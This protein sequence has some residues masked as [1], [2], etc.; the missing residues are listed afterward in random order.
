MDKKLVAIDLDGTTLNNQSQLTQRTE[1]AIRKVI[2]QG[3]I[4]SIATGRPFRTSQQFYQQLNLDT[5]IVNFNGAWC[6]HPR[7]YNWAN[8]YHKRLDRDV[9]LS[10][11]PLKRYNIV[12]LISAE[13]KS[14]VYVDRTDEETYTMG[15]PLQNTHTIPFNEDTLNES[16]TS[17][18]VFTAD[19]H[20]IPF[21][22]VACQ[23]S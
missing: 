16:P 19:E 9:A 21:S 8:G 5:P 18:N 15:S 1:E 6:H 4:V 23:L 2:E 22:T 10:F 7:D 17:V 13:S 3:H 12:K 11:L 14:N 20:F